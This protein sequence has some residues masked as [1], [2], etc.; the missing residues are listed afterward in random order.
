MPKVGRSSVASLIRNLMP[1]QLSRIPGYTKSGDQLL[2]GSHEKH[3]RHGLVSTAVSTAKLIL[4]HR[5]LLVVHMACLL[6][7]GEWRNVAEQLRSDLDVQR[8][9]YA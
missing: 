4:S 1:Q 5:V 7:R 9:A 8:A 2:H 3:G 6:C